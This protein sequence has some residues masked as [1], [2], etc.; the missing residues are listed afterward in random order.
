MIGGVAY[1]PIATSTVNHDVWLMGKI[2]L[3]GL[4]EIHVREGEANEVW[5]KRMMYQ[6]MASG[7]AVEVLGG[8]LVPEA[9][10]VAGWTPEVAAKTVEHLGSLTEEADKEAI[11]GILLTTLLSFFELGLCSVIRSPTS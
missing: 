9:I 8:L 2:H 3:A 4:S 6:L 7:Q 1:V 11:F 10:G 5:A